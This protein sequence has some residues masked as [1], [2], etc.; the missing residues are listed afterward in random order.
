MGGGT[1]LTVL[2][3]FSAAAGGWSLGMHR[4]GFRTIA[5]CEWIDWRRTL[6]AENNP[7]VPIY[8]DVRSVTAE[9]LYAD[10]GTLPWGVFGSPPC[11]DISSANTKGKG[12]DGERSVLFFEAIR[13]AR[14]IRSLA[15]ELGVPGARWLGLEN[16]SN[17]RNRGSDRVISALEEAGYAGEPCVVG[18]GDDF[19]TSGRKVAGVGANHERARSWLIFFD[20]AQLAD[21]NGAGRPARWSG[22]RSGL[23]L[24]VPYDPLDAAE[25]RHAG[26]RSRRHRPDGDGSPPTSPSHAGDTP[27]DG[28]GPRWQ[29][30]RTQ[31]VEGL[32]E[33]ARGHAGSPDADQAGQADGCLESSLRQAE[34]ARPGRSDVPSD[35]SHA[36]EGREPDGA[37]NDE[38]GGGSSAGGDASGPWA[39]WNGG[40]AHHLRVDDGLSA[41]VAGARVAVGGPRGTSAASLI[42]EAFGDAVIPQIPEAIG[43]AILRTEAALAAIYGHPA[44]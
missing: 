35:G 29:G 20:P 42:V 21:P 28:C 31:P 34:I 18:A 41:W 30:R 17:L 5:A 24:S 19:R 38:V 25:V 44:A 11:Q 13:I 7:G 9:R 32:S 43:R 27:Q 16:S 4:A 3:L 37:I 6:Y 8:D 22:W 33:Q 1:D 36:N 14:E 26:G 2:D 10:L 23:D 12:V 39:E 15:R 40:L